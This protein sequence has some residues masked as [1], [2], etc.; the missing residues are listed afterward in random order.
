MYD[1]TT[2]EA[3]DKRLVQAAIEMGNWLLKQDSV[4]PNQRQIIQGVQKALLRLPAPTLTVRCSYGFVIQDKVIADW[5]RKSQPPPEGVIMGWSVDIYLREEDG[6]QKMYVEI[7]N[8]HNTWTNQTYVEFKASGID[9]E[10]E[11]FAK[12]L[13]FYGRFW[14]EPEKPSMDICRM[15]GPDVLNEWIQ[16]AQDPDKLM[17]DRNVMEIEI[18]G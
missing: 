8:F 6:L 5:D 17:N 15:L 7:A 11:D 10:M 4:T 18:S 12:E 16:A 9:H 1:P 3:D 2:F 14:G 13:L